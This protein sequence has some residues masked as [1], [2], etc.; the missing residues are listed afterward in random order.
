MLLPHGLDGAGP[1]HSSSRV[2]RMLQVGYRILIYAFDLTLFFVALQRSIYS[3]HRWQAFKCQRARCL[4]DNASP[5]LP[6]PSKADEA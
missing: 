2:E 6:P 4:S 1:E 5:I 3:K